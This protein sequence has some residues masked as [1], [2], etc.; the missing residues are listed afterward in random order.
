MSRELD[1]PLWKLLLITAVSDEALQLTC[2]ECYTLLDYLADTAV[3]TQ[4]W[5]A[6]IAAAKRHMTCCPDCRD[7]YQ[8]RLAE[9][10]T[11]LKQNKIHD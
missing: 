3:R 6:V 11:L 9:I 2:G 8:A 10:E 7:Y 5:P 1:R 4:N